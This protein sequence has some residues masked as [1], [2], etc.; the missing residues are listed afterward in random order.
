[1]FSPFNDERK[2]CIVCL[3]SVAVT[4]RTNC[5]SGLPVRDG[6]ERYGG[7]AYF[8]EAWRTVMIVD[9]GLQEDSKVSR[10]Q[11]TSPTFKHLEM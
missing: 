4:C 1:M 5:L 3:F 8:N 6:F 10:G 7:D 11:D 9:Q 2:L